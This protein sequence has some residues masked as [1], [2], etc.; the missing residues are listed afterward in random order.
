MRSRRRGGGKIEVWKKGRRN[1]ERDRDNFSIYRIMTFVVV[2]A[3]RKSY[4]WHFTQQYITYRS[5]SV[6]MGMKL[7]FPFLMYTDSNSQN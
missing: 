5:Q 6:V 3:S 7:I 4:F 2:Y 1:G